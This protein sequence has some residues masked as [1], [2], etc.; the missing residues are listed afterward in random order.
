MTMGSDYSKL[1]KIFDPAAGGGVMFPFWI[2]VNIDLDTAS[3]QVLGDFAF[4]FK[5]RLVTAHAFCTTAYT[6]ASTNPVIGIAIGTAAAGSAG[7]ATEV[8]TITC[9]SPGV[10][11]T[12]EV[13]P[14]NWSG[15]T[16]PT[17][18]ATTQSIWVYLKT[19]AAAGS[20]PSA[21]QDG[22]VQVCLWLAQLNA[23]A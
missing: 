14:T 15:S 11:A 3:T 23:P 19:A 2:P 5:V 9:T 7:A 1:N 10:V 8:S 6:T 21:A 12:T 13:A 17:D 20:Y 18:I 22:T 16:T 4:P